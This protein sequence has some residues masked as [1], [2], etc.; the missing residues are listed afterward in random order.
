MKSIVTVLALLLLVPAP[1]AVAKNVDLATVPPRDS[2]QLTIYNS[3]DLTLVRE[4]R[5]VSFKRGVNTLQFAWAGTLIDPTS[6][7]LRFATHAD[8][9]ELSDTTFPHDKPQ[10]LYWNVAS[11]LDGDAAVEISYFTSG[12]TWEADYVAIAGA[13]ESR[14]DL[15]GFVRVHNRSGEDYEGASV[16]VVVGT[17]NLVEK[18]AELAR[19]SPAEVEQLEEVE[20]HELRNRAARKM[21]ERTMGAAA[22]AAADA[23]VYRE[24][25]IIKEGLSEYF[26]FTIEGEE[27]IPNGWSKRLRSFDGADVPVRVQYRYRPPQYG[28]QLVRLYLLKNDVAS[29]LGTTPL[30]GGTVRIFRENGRGGLSYLTSQQVPYVPVGEDVELNLGPDPEVVFE[31]VTRRVRRENI[32][33]KLHGADVYRQVEPGGLDIDV[34][35]SVAGW[36]ERASRVQWIRN[37]TR[38]PIEVEVRRTLPGHVVF[39]S[40]L[41]AKAHDYQTVEY[42]A[43]V[44]PGRSVGLEYD[45]IRKHGRNAKQNNVTITAG[46]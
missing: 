28:D 29:Q 20:R 5:V 40:T 43:T 3:E 7:E 32:W 46:S 9:L 22:P 27:T 6:V 34:R 8:R 25:K 17:I 19:V 16:R 12:I 18:V 45:V 30:P 35:S 2:V 38:R 15:D 11:E 10:M 24:K 23:A 31:L 4:T 13:G 21:M 41:D 26:I 44:P 42:T 14:L 36:D 39:E 33:M 1:A 37:Y